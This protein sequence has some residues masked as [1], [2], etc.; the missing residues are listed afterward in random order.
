MGRRGSVPI[1]MHLETLA[2][3]QDCP[4]CAGALEAS[5]YKGYDAVRCI[6]CGTPR[7]VMWG[8]ESE[9]DRRDRRRGGERRPVLTR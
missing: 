4:E 8:E 6:D 1:G 7:I 5:S 3:R 9:L 2:T